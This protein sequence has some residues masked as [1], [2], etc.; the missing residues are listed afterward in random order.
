M[1]FLAV[2]RLR[3]GFILRAVCVLRRVPHFSRDC[4]GVVGEARV[5]VCG[6]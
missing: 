3:S 6:L 4:A 1:G 5:F 2:L